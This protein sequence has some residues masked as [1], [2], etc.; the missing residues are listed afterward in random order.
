MGV[1][2]LLASVASQGD[3]CCESRR[4]VNND[5]LRLSSKGSRAAGKCCV[6]GG[7][8]GYP[9]CWQVLCRREVLA[10]E[11]VNSARVRCG[12]PRT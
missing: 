4:C 1:P 2:T 9:R 5:V 7:P 8:R 12:G 6:A 11:Y 10:V 3:S